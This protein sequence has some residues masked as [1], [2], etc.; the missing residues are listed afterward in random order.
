MLDA[1]R[2]S[3]PAPLLVADAQRLPFA[4]ASFDVVLANAHAA[5]RTRPRACVE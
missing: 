2:H 3:S 1:A 5:S 4:D